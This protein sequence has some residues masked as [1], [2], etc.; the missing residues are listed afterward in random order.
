M[1]EGQGRIY[2][3]KTEGDREGGITR[4]E[5]EGDREGGMREREAGRD[6]GGREGEREPLD[7]GRKLYLLRLNTNRQ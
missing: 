7:R 6:G 5:T 4:D 1:R 2:S 3:N